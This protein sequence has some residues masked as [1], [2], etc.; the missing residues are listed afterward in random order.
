VVVLDIH[1]CCEVVFLEFDFIKKKQKRKENRLKDQ[2][3]TFW[4]MY[5]IWKFLKTMCQLEC[6]KIRTACEEQ[7]DIIL[8]TQK[9]TYTRGKNLLL[10]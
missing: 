2:T 1:I 5:V 6:E 4:Y 10:P 3:G 7:S 8:G 9:L